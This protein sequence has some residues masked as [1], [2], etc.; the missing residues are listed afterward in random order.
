MLCLSG[1]AVVGPQAISAGC[2]A[3]T[4]TINRTE[5]EQTLNMLVR[6]RYDETFGMMSVASVTAGLRF[7]AQ[8]ATNTGIGDSDLCFV[9][10]QVQC[11]TPN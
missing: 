7:R 5:D 2:G 8:A 6:T 11:D 10:G 9:K 1:C 3:Y 4:E